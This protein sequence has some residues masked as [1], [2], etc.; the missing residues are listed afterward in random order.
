[1]GTSVSVWNL[2]VYIHSSYNLKVS[3]KYNLMWL[4]WK[5]LLGLINVNMKV[6]RIRRLFGLSFI[7]VSN[8]NVQ[9]TK[10]LSC[11]YCALCFQNFV[12]E[13]EK[14]KCLLL[15]TTSFP[16]ILKTRCKMNTM[17]D[18]CNYLR[19]RVNWQL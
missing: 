1:M 17:L 9:F 11:I 5:R 14:K 19:K 15:P 10:I 7:F 4:I 3:S 8:Y 13:M 6:R 12:M 18:F 2:V 16:K